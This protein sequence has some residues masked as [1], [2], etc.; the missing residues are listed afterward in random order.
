MINLNTQF[1][2]VKSLIWTQSEG[3]VVIMDITTGKYYGLNPVS[4][5]IFLRC[6]NEISVKDLISALMESY[7]VERSACEKETL[8]MLNVFLKKG[9]I[10][11]TK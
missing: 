10:E 1:V 4:S 3:E 2:R 11:I 6:S 9:I 8:D 7:T 5:D